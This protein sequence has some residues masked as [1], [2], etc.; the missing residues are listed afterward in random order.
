M[1]LPEG[2]G[3]SR[4]R[5]GKAACQQA[6]PFRLCNGVVPQRSTICLSEIAAADPVPRNDFLH[7]VVAFSRGW[8][9]DGRIGAMEGSHPGG[10][11]FAKSPD[12]GCSLVSRVGNMNTGLFREGLRETADTPFPGTCFRNRKRGRLTGRRRGGETPE[13]A[14]LTN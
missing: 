1:P 9:P 14:H 3:F 12:Y 10:R 11:G 13:T 7:P 4:D 5:D 8:A 2:T 6:A